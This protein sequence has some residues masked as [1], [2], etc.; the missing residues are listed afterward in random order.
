MS[1]SILDKIQ[2]MEMARGKAME[3]AK[4][5]AMEMATGKAMKIMFF[6]SELALERNTMILLD[7]TDTVSCI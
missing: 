5:K 4:G 7:P 1:H 2:A 6:P 3:T